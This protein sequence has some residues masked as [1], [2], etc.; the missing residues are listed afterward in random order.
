MCVCSSY[1]RTKTLRGEKE[2]ERWS[3]K[4]VIH[5]SSSSRAAASRYALCEWF[6]NSEINR[7]VTDT[8]CDLTKLKTLST[9]SRRFMTTSTAAQ[10]QHMTVIDLA[11]NY[12]EGSTYTSKTKQINTDNCSIMLLCSCHLR[13]GKLRCETMRE[14]TAKRRVHWKRQKKQ[15]IEESRTSPKQHFIFSRKK[16]NFC[17]QITEIMDEKRRKAIVF[18]FI[19]VHIPL[20]WNL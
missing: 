10:K 11:A 7:F 13:F 15:Q 18:I 9:T 2:K 20:G 16:G 12:C 4:N 3:E 1:Q 19:A 5:Y 8:Q 14:K 6:Q 17:R